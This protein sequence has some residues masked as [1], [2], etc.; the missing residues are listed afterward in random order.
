MALDGSPARHHTLELFRCPLYKDASCHDQIDRDDG[1]Q[2]DT[3]VIHPAEKF[4]HSYV[5]TNK[6]NQVVIASFNDAVHTF[7]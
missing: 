6:K 1:L 4:T 5:G 7:G 2:G 3:N